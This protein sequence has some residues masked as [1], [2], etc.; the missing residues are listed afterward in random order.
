LRRNDIRSIVNSAHATFDHHD[1]DGGSSSRKNVVGS[2]SG[3]L[4][5]GYFDL[6]VFG[7]KSYMSLGCVVDLF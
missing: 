7:D 3:F 2:S 6:L 4:E 5:W 1:I